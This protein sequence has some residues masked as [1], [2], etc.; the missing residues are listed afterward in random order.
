MPYTS[1]QLRCLRGMGL[2]P[3]V[4]RAYADELPLVQEI[5]EPDTFPEASVTPEN[6]L[7]S[8]LVEIPF[9]G[10]HTTQLGN[11]DSQLL[12]FVEAKS[13]QQD[14]YPFE[15]NDA[16]LFDDMLR[17]IHWRRQ[18]V[19]LAVLPPSDS[20]LEVTTDNSGIESEC[21]ADLLKTHRDV[22]LVFTHRVPETLNADDMQLS[23][24]RPGT[25]AWQLP[26]PALLQDEP[27]RKRQAWN[28]LKLARNHLQGHLQGH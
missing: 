17:A 4:E 18:D 3:W 10:Q 16:R 25:L 19:C 13:M 24:N 2:V 12:V 20:Q 27:I 21:A 7:R 9:R 14:Q 5:N 8:T 28:V 1:S 23:L 26:H 15:A 22:V 6:F 11:T